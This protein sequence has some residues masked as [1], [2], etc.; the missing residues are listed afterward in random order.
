MVSFGRRLL[1]LYKRSNLL[2]ARMPAAGPVVVVLTRR[3]MLD[4][5]LQSKG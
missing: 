1:T 3:P 2:A 4:C 5:P